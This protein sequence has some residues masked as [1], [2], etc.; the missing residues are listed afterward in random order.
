MSKKRLFFSASH[1]EDG[2][3]VSDVTG[4]AESSLEGFGAIRTILN[5]RTNETF[6]E[7][8][9]TEGAAAFDPSGGVYNSFPD[10]S[11]VHDFIGGKLYHKRASSVWKYGAINT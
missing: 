10:N 2:M 3:A 8:F 9:W 5:T 6:Y 7:C 11:I 1:G 4:I